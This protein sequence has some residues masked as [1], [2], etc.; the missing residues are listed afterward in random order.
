MNKII[1]SILYSCSV[2]WRDGGHH[3]SDTN[4]E[5]CRKDVSGSLDSLINIIKTDENIVCRIKGI[6][7]VKRRLEAGEISERQAI[8]TLFQAYVE[9][10]NIHIKNMMLEFF[11]GH[12]DLTLP[13]M[14][15]CPL[16]DCY[17][18]IPKLDKSVKKAAREIF[19]KVLKTI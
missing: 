2:R 6:D 11:K 19:R 12:R 7:E 18:G 9:N 5:I 13:L 4:V 3:M 14:D 16:M 1:S 15:C 8:E 10:D 17:K